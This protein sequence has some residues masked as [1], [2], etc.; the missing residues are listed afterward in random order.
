MEEKA[1]IYQSPDCD[2]HHIELQYP[3]AASSLTLP[4]PFW[5]DPVIW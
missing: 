5:S 4:E 1:L 2:T 3:V